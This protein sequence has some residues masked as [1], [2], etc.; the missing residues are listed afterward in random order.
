MKAAFFACKAMDQAP[1]VRNVASMFRSI[2]GS[3]IRPETVRQ[4]LAGFALRDTLGTQLG[5]GADTA[6]PNEKGRLGYR[7]DTPRTPSPVR[8][9]NDLVTTYESTEEPSAPRRKRSPR[10]PALPIDAD[11]RTLARSIRDAVL[12]LARPFFA[13]AMSPTVWKKRQA[14]AADE[15]ARSGLTPERVVAAWEW[16]RSKTGEGLYSLRRL[17][18]VMLKAY[19]ER[20]QRR[21]GA[22][23]RPDLQDVDEQVLR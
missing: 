10:Q 11:V 3:G 12:P 2:A 6:A 17:H 1:S 7:R 8:A 23:V 19:A 21:G 15:M 16:H 18:E 9:L 13:G 14:A 5:H 22:D 20:E 4:F